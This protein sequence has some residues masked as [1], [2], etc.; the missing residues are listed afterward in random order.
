MAMLN[1]CEC[2]LFSVVFSDVFISFD[3]HLT[4][5]RRLFGPSLVYCAKRGRFKNS[6]G[7][8]MYITVFLK[9]TLISRYVMLF[10]FFY[11]PLGGNHIRWA[12]DS[13]QES[14]FADDALVFAQLQHVSTS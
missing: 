2:L 1:G 7:P 10:F 3:S 13:N 5:S 14:K 6:A 4:V 11:A 12:G 8:K 9:L